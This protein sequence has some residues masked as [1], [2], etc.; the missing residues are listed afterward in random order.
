MDK[1]SIGD[2]RQT[3]KT[4]M[5]TYTL[6]IL[7]VHSNNNEKQANV[8][9]GTTSNFVICSKKEVASP[10]SQS[11]QIKITFKITSRA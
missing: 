1:N 5:Y 10:I 8:S 9:V 6:H 7:H 11:H 2:R 3:L 4:A